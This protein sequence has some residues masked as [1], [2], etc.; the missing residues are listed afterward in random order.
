MGQLR[1][2]MPVL[3]VFAVVFFANAAVGDPTGPES[4]PADI[5]GPP[6]GLTQ[7]ETQALRVGNEFGLKLLRVRKRHVHDE[8]PEAAG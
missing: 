6:R 5:T 1:S 4:R 8:G 7:A 3:L 2:I